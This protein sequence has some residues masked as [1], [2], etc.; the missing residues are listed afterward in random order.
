MSRRL[1][2]LFLGWPRRRLSRA[3]GI[4][5]SIAA[6][7]VALPLWGSTQSATAIA[8][9]LPI[10]T[11]PAR[12]PQLRP[13]NSDGHRALSGPP[14]PHG[15]APELGPTGP[16]GDTAPST[17]PTG[18]SGPCP[19][20]VKLTVSAGVYSASGSGWREGETID[21]YL[22]TA[23]GAHYIGTATATEPQQYGAGYTTWGFA[24]TPITPFL[25][26]LYCKPYGVTTRNY[27]VRFPDTEDYPVV[28]MGENQTPGPTSAAT[29]TKMTE[30]DVEAGFSQ[31]NDEQGERNYNYYGS[32]EEQDYPFSPPPHPATAPSSSE[33]ESGLTT[34]GSSITRKK[35]GKPL[36]LASVNWY[37]AEEAD[38][39]PGGLQCQPLATIAE[40][41]RRLGFN[42]VR[43]PWSNAMFEIDPKVC[44]EADLHTLEPCIPPEVL[45]ANPELAKSGESARQIFKATVEALS[46]AHLMVILDNHGTDAAFEPVEAPHNNSVKEVVSLDG[47]WWGGQYWDNLY[48]FG[49]QP[50]QRTKLWVED[51]EKLVNE[52]KED[53]RV[54]G[55]DLRN[56]PSATPYS[57]GSDALCTARWSGG[58]RQECSSDLRED[59]PCAAREA[60]DKILKVKKQLLIF[61]E[62][63]N[64]A[65]DL[66]AVGETPELELDPKSQLVYSA[67][68]YPFDH[69]TSENWYE[70]WGYIMDE[71]NAPVWIGEFGAGA[72]GITGNGCPIFVFGQMSQ[73]Q[74][75]SCL[76][77]YVTE[78]GASW[79]WWAINGTA[80]DGGINFKKDRTYYEPESYGLLAP[81][82][83]DEASTTLT[84][85]LQ[86][87][88]GP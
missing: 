21:I 14:G 24:S 13:W 32:C 20:T 10:T 27:C 50:Q 6:A 30:Q 2:P 67:H 43:L 33:L 17:C 77:E 22:D 45:A 62:G 46:R 29:I 39:V 58:W 80:S 4:K 41:I 54:I 74:W 60:G 31:T 44:T 49:A 75:L 7:L 36:T 68:T 28:A 5:A 73:D 51:W 18:T 40:E 59:W 64:S 82:W 85:E 12:V 83:C 84:E 78:V 53:P 25:R 79:S 9:R 57:C 81:C 38:F 66:S 1:D 48:G 76:H 87:M 71:E 69:Q 42:T 63:T 34:S 19:P 56:E 16:T 11:P 3:G 15:L 86:Q 8:D 23:E 70:Q 72:A 37:G 88:Q 52:F 35:G 47:L 55:A 61:V 65:L 26:L